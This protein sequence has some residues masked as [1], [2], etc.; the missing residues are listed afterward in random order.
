MLDNSH[1]ERVAKGDR[2]AFKKLHE[3]L[4]QR[5][6]YYVYKILHDKEQA[7]DIIQDTFVLFWGNRS[8][9][10]NLLA[11]KTYLYTVVKNKVLALIRDTANRKRIL[12]SIE[13]E[14][15]TTEDNIL[16]SAEICGQVQQAIRELPTQTRRV[17]ELSMQE[18][19]VEKIAEEM[20]ISPNTVKT[21]K[22]VGYQ[23]LRVK[24]KHLRMVLFFLSVG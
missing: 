3:E 7:E 1:I 15:S 20:Q 17:I 16:I 19:T 23:A 9:F 10:N 11:V 4:Y 8:N 12:E 6:F 14:E 5:M 18:M 2:V 22:K 24:L 21:L 13:W